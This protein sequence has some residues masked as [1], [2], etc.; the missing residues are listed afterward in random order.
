MIGGLAVHLGLPLALSFG[1]V[2]AMVYALG[3]RIA[4]PSIRDLD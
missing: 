2:V 1:G 4:M 3:L